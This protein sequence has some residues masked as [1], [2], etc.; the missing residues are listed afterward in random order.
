[1]LGNLI[2]GK[3]STLTELSSSGKS[4]SFFYFTEDSNFIIYNILIKASI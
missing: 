1:M 4:G 3:L 2:M